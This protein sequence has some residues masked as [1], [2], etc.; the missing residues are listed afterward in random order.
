MA[1]C[2]VEASLPAPVVGRATGRYTGR[3][4]GLKPAWLRQGAV[5]WEKYARLR[6]LISVLK[7]NTVCVEVPVS[8]HRR[9]MPTITDSPRKPVMLP[10]TWIEQTDP[11]N[12]ISVFEWRRNRRAAGREGDGVVMTTVMV[13]EDTCTHGCMFL[14]SILATSL[15]HRIP[16]SLLTQAWPLQYGGD[17]EAVSALANYGL[18]DLNNIET[19]RSMQRI[20]KDPRAGQCDTLI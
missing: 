17:L 12:L 4:P 11:V 16:W 15:R 6:D 9:V 20:I 18:N 13:L 5:Q 2:R 14:P 1:Q 10:S 19:V 8:Q 7:L 3:D